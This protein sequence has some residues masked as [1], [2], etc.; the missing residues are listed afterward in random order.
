MRRLLLILA[1]VLVFL[2]IAVPAV[3]I[4]SA[5]RTQSGLQFVARHVPHRIGGVQLDI[6]GVSGTLASGVHVDRV[7]IDHDLVHLTFTDIDGQVMLA[8]LMLQTIRVS[9]GHVH[10]ALIQVKRRT[11]P[12]TSSPPLFLPRWLLIS[13]EQARVDQ[14]RLTVFNGV[15]LTARDINGAAVLRHKVIRFF[16]ADGELEDAHISAIGELLAADPLGMEVKGRIQWQ[17][18]GQPAYTVS[19]TGRGD[20]NVLNIVAHSVS[21]FTADVSGQMRDLTNHWHWVGDAVV[22]KF[23]LTPWGVNAP[24]LGNITGHLAVSGDANGFEG[25][26]PVTPAGLHAGEF[27]GQFAGHYANR[28]LT[29][30]HMEVRHLASGA[31][32][33]GSGTFGIV[34]KGPLLDLRGSWN[35]FRWPLVGR[36]V[37][38]RSAAGTFTLQGIL[39]Y[40]VRLSGRGRAA[41]FAEMPVDLTGTLGKD[42]FAFAPAEVDLFDGHANASGVVTWAPAET[43]SVNGRATG[44]NPGL[45]RGDLPGSVAFAFAANGRGFDE[46]GTLSA[47]FTGLSG[48]VRGVAAS[49]S[50]TVTRTAAN[51]GFDN[52]RVGLGSASLALDGRIN[53]PVDLRFAVTTQDLGLLAPG[54]R[55]VLKL[56]GNVR[57][58]LSDPAIV[59]SGHGGGIDYQGIKIDGL[60][61]DIN[62]N[63]GAEHEASKIEARVR[64]LTYGGRTVDTVALTLNG[65]PAGYHVQLAAT[66]TGLAAHAAATGAYS[67]GVFR[68]QLDALA[69]KGNESLQL[70]LERPVDLTASLGHVRVE[71]LCLVGEPGSICADGEWTPARWS[72][73]VMANQLPLNSLTAGMTPAVEYR[74]MVNAL[75]RLAGG[76]QLPVTGT[77]RAELNNAVL[78]HKLASRRLEHT[79]IGSGVITLAA[80]P[81]AISAELA[82]TESEVG[83]LSGAF[84]AQRTRRGTSPIATYAQKTSPVETLAHWQDM[85]LSGELHAHT[86]EVGLLSL[87]FPD[88]DRA[89]GHLDVDLKA[90]GTLG[91]PLLTGE[92]KLADGEINNY[93]V[94]LR[95]RQVGFDA[96]LTDAGLDFQGGAHAGAGTVTVGG[97]LEW[98][99]LLAYGK[100]HLQGENLRVADVP[101][102]QIDASP[103]LDFNI[104]GH[105]I[106]VTGQVTVPFAKIAPRDITNAV[107]ASQDEVIV[108]SEVDDPTKRFEVVSTITLNVGERVNVDASGLTARIG[109]NITIINGYDAITHAKGELSVAEGKYTAYGRKLDIQYGHLLFSGGPV[110]NPVINLRAQKEFPDVTA[111]VDV[112]GTLQSPHLSFFSN[113]PL[114]QSQI[115]SLILS[116]GS[117]SSAPGSNG[118]GAGNLAVGQAAAILGQQYGSLVGIQDVSVESDI[119]NETSLVLGRY[120]SPRLYVSYGVSL[121]QQLNTIKLRYTLGDHWAVKIEAGQARGAD[122]VYSIER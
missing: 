11:R 27:A 99:N 115:Q 78:I 92:V 63:P 69:I 70:A 2:V 100:F 74:G 105:K 9:S 112:R 31:H 75:A 57:G 29:A 120:L 95:L 79:N 65:P 8:P 53:E 97:H 62:F 114:P 54:S 59:A 23:D 43:W 61:A 98:R 34:D 87:Y 117:L 18:P 40:K 17:P 64:K 101:E 85:P 48:K 76:A 1:C 111:G 45:F 35:D 13:I 46:A 118:S 5:V 88:V 60:D 68:G 106:G 50:G 32:A 39:P 7:E 84:Q 119:T 44:I 89:A 94:N 14:A 107:R 113:P 36:Y 24:L 103:N 12:P 116:G 71:W 96:H 56:A 10:N 22:R 73:T 121:T 15:T 104:N 122:L 109:G 58:T 72:S 21:P 80:T 77:L 30:T 93:Q 67:H 82:L 83:T 81:A 108:G 26:G 66:A 6:S 41:D 91:T 47:S 52:L 4:W 49:G 110:D 55:G 37:A 33:V 38:V 102:A 90:A 19:G 16:Q 20:L 42:N 28:V 3:I 51:W 25:H 86:A